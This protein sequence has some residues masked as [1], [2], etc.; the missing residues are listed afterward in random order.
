MAV[1]PDPSGTSTAIWVISILGN[2]PR[3]IRDG[4]GQAAVSPDGSRIAFIAGRRQAEL[5]LMGADGQEAR[6]LKAGLDSE[7]FLQLQWLPQGGRIALLKSQ[8]E[9]I[10]AEKAVIETLDPDNGTSQLILTDPKLRSFCWLPDGRLVYSREEPAPN[11]SD[12]NLWFI[13][14]DQSTGKPSGEARRITSWVGFSFSDLSVTAD[15][16][17]L[18]FVKAG[19]QS[20]VYVG[21]LLNPRQFVKIERLTLDERNDWPGAWLPDSSSLLFS[22]DRNGGWDLFKQGKDNAVAEDFLVGPDEQSEPRLTPDRTSVL[23]WGYRSEASGAPGRLRLM[24]VPL[25]GGP[26]QLLLEVGW[27]AQQ[28]CAASASAG[29]VVGEQSQDRNQLIFSGFDP[30]RGAQ[31]EFLRVPIEPSSTPV[32]DLSPDGSRLAMVADEHKNAILIV[33]L[34]SG[35]SRDVKLETAV[36]LSGLTWS[37]DADGWFVTGLAERRGVLLYVH[38]SGKAQELW[39]SQSTL[40]APVLSPD[41]KNLAFAVST[42]NSNAWMLESF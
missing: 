29:C 23:Y 5:W 28:R 22:S 4:A 42:Q 9:N 17:R 19:A 18:V 11:S 31:H 21:T 2:S 25:A 36:S 12:T 41:G 40:A 32:W 16:K 34:R 26:P 14:V 30:G 1:G 38:S 8:S 6:R 13:P 35:T 24:R 37:A 20:D 33:E 7:R 15:G 3:K 10:P 27:G 39:S